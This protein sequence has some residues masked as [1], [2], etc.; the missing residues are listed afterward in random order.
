MVHRFISALL[1]ESL[2][3]FPALLLLGARQVG[4]STLAQQLVREGVL[5]RY[6]TL[7]DLGTLEAARA[8][9]N[10]FVGSYSGAVALDEIQRVPDLMRALKKNIDARREPG[11]FLLTG[12]A[13]V[14]AQREVSESLAGRVDVVF[15]EGLSAGELLGPAPPSSFLEDVLSAAGMAEL[16]D[17]LG[18]ALARAPALDRDTLDRLMFYGG[19]PEVA[20]RRSPRFAA[21]W[22]AA[23]QSTYIERDVRELGRLSDVVPFSK[24]LRL[25][26]LRTANLLNRHSLGADVGLDQRT[27]GRYLDLLEV[28]LQIHRLAPWHRNL[29]KR[30]VKAPKIFL[31]DS[32]M[33]CHLCG[34]TGPERLRAHPLYGALA[35]TWLF[36][37]L[38]KLLPQSPG[39]SLGFYRTHAGREVDFILERGPRLC[40]IEMKLAESV[41]RDD[42]KGL[43][44]MQEAL[45]EAAGDSPEA[46]GVLLYTGAE[47]VRFGPSLLAV[48]LRCLF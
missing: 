20:L 8:D 13:N 32:G 9:P 14:L 17:R 19:F 18:A 39:I 26:A 36:A 31:N 11:R 21:R 42:F 22:F 40:G 33:A 24:L 34:V 4:K 23:Y 35:E 47:L 25:V 10:G 29:G 1:P 28:T 12:S 6:V 37:E 46:L 43:C 2:K 38:R 48:P 3:G 15:L 7:D 27:V 16:Q 30:L 41:T 44:D 45:R 5:G